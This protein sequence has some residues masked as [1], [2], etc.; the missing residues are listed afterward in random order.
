[1]HSIH[2]GGLTASFLL[3]KSTELW[4]DK[5]NTKE[6]GRIMALIKCPE[7]GK[8]I[9]DKA[10]YCPNCGCPS[11]EFNTPKELSENENP[12]MFNCVN[13]G[14]PLPV[15]IEECIYCN[16]NYKEG[17]NY[18]DKEIK[19]HYTIIDIILMGI[20]LILGMFSVFVSYIIDIFNGYGAVIV[21][22][23]IFLL[24]RKK[25]YNTLEKKPSIK[26]CEKC[27]SED[28]NFTF[29]QKGSYSSS[30][31][32][33][34]NMVYSS[35]INDNAKIAVCKNCGFSWE[36]IRSEEIILELSN[37]KKWYNFLGLSTVLLFAFAMSIS[38]L[39]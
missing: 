35:S 5:I 17:N 11:K 21:Y 30:Y 34:N 26:K 32:S 31:V 19:C 25:Y 39:W 12:Q 28:I 13:C 4:Y 3:E 37:I 1:M 27:E 16:Y 22:T 14:R 38:T 33:N 10:T 7:C 6:G 23:I 18:S 2:R 15:G 8:E 9:S 20:V 29:L 36:F 24:I